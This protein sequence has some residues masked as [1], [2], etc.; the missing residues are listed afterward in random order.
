MDA[1]LVKLR[2]RPGAEAIDLG[3]Q[4]A[5]ASWPRLVVVA[6]LA[7]LPTL[8][9]AALAFAWQPPL[10]LLVVWWLKPSLDRPL[11]HLLGRELIGERI[12]LARLL[13]ERQQWWTGLHLASLTVYRLHPSRSFVLPVWLLEGLSGDSRRRRTRALGHGSG[14]SGAG[15][16]FM[17]SLFELVI[18]AGLFALFGWLLPAS[19][20][21]GLNAPGWIGPGGLADELWA[22]LALA[23]AV[24]IILVEPFY[25][26][27]GFGLYLNQRCRLECWDLEPALRRLADRATSPSEAVP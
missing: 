19:V 8:L 14:S 15:L 7:Q 16:G 24:T 12:G 13:R 1:E 3:L 21:E 5:R 2:P 25:V 26:G 11:L 17:S 9:L 4:L 27:A 10:A 23:Y 18:M 20:W 6:L 22:A